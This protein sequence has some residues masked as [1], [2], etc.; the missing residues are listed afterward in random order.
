MQSVVCLQEVRPVKSTS[1]V[2]KDLYRRRSDFLGIQGSAEQGK[3]PV[4]RD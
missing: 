2:K 1:A 4:L 3:F